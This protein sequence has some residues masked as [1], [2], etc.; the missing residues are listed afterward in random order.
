M[1]GRHDRDREA[2]LFCGH[3]PQMAYIKYP[4]Y[5]EVTITIR[6]TGLQRKDSP[7]GKCSRKGLSD[8]S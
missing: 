3:A 5:Q 7:P 4:I 1:P 2:K 6:K 8:W